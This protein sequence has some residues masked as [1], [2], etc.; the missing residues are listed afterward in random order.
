MVVSAHACGLP[1]DIKRLSLVEPQL[2]L[3]LS[4]DIVVALNILGLV[5]SRCFSLETTVVLH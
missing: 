5:Y 2:D 1:V 3:S 4:Y